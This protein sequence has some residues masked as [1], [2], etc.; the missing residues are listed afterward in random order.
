MAEFP[1]S[2]GLSRSRTALLS[3]YTALDPKLRNELVYVGLAFPAG[4]DPVEQLQ[5]AARW[6]RE[7]QDRPRIHRLQLAFATMAV[8]DELPPTPETIGDFRP[9]VAELVDEE[10]AADDATVM[11]VFDALRRATDEDVP[12]N[13]RWAFVANNAGPRL[14]AELRKIDRA[15]CDRQLRSVDG[16]IA[17]RIETALEV[18][19]GRG[20]DQL[21]LAVLPDNWASC[22]DF[23]CSLTRTLDR[24]VN[25]PGSTG[26]NLSPALTHWRGVY[27]ERVGRCPAGWFPDTYLVV[28]WDR[29]P[30]QLIL[31]YELAPR[32]RND[33]TVLRIDQGY[34]QVDRLPGS[35]QV[36]TVKYLLFD[37]TFIPGGGQ[38][39]AAAACQLGWLDCSVNQFTTCADQLNRVEDGD[40]ADR[41]GAGIDAGMQE[42]LDRCQ[43]HLQEAAADAD[44]RFGKAVAR[45]GAGDYGLDDYVVDWG[46]A[47]T[48]AIRDGSRSLTGQADLAWE[49]LDVAREL[50]R[51]RTG[52]R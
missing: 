52:R 30:S 44:K 37:D 18:R 9:V 35:Y 16:E 5:V 29:S 24:D 32:R 47:V 51:R 46:Q 10:V 42:V 13:Q 49:Y 6:H 20:L 19:D 2:T 28:T 17:T 40:T 39:L 22:N 14:H 26:G 48:Q 33:H 36:S 25:C 43:T 11:E 41:P 34:I 21:A 38:S 3:V 50:S 4:L 27:E 12:V 31:R 23:F 8:M 1:P 7:E 45:V 15:W